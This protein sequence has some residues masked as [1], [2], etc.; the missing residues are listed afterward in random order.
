M[1][2]FRDA[3]E[4]FGIRQMRNENRRSTDGAPWSFLC[5]P[6]WVAHFGHFIFNEMLQVQ[7]INAAKII[8]ATC[9]EHEM[10]DAFPLIAELASCIT[11]IE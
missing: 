11:Q 1:V 10:I 9:I 2:N 4:L 6:F 5:L 3:L 7:E 8:L